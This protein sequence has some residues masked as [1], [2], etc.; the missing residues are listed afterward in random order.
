MSLPNVFQNRNISDNIENQQLIYYG[1]G[2]KHVETKKVV[3]GKNID[4]KLKR[5][6]ASTNYV[7]KLNVTIITNKEP[8]KTTIV[9]K[10]N[11][12]LITYD[13]KLIPLKE[14]IDIYEN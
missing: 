2:N 9:G 11:T 12:N 3:S 13:N 5:I 4:E 6:F 8:I 10:T 14:I 7:Y 1:D